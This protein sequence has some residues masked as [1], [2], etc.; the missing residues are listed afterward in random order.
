MTAQV[1]DQALDGR[2]VLHATAFTHRFGVGAADRAGPVQAA[3]EDPHLQRVQRRWSLI[4]ALQRVEQLE[5]HQPGQARQGEL[6]GRDPGFL[7]GD[8]RGQ[9]LLRHRREVALPLQPIAVEPAQSSPGDAFAPAAGHQT[10]RA[11]PQ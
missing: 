3:D 7:V 5:A 4:A 11:A 1:T 10:G 9:L 2:V 8:P 6:V